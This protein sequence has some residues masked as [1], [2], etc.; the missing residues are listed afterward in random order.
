MPWLSLHVPT[1]VSAAATV[2]AAL[3]LGLVLA[4]RGQHPALHGSLGPWARG[5]LLLAMGWLLLAFRD[6]WPA[7]VSMLLSNTLIGFGLA[8]C[9]DALRRF[10]GCKRRLY[11]PLLLVAGIVL[12][13]AVFGL[14]M[15]D[16][17]LRLTINTALLAGLF[18]LGAREA[19]AAGAELR[20]GTRSHLLVAGVF[21]VAA[22][23]L[24][25]RVAM[26][27]WLGRQDM[28]ASGDINLIQALF[29]GLAALG[30]AVAT[31]GFALMCNDRLSLELRR[32]AEEDA[33]T[34]VSNRRHIERLG[35]H[36]EESGR[37]HSEPFS[38]VLI[39]IDHF[40]RVNDDFG[41]A[42]GDVVLRQLTRIMQEAAEPFGATVGRIGGEEFVLLLHG[43]PLSSALA[44]AES[45]RA[46]AARSA[47]SRLSWTLSAGVAQACPSDAS[48]EALLRR[49][50]R[51]LYAAKR[52]GRNCIRTAE[53][54]APGAAGPAVDGD[55]AAAG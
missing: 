20:S 55:V 21:A 35:R 52:G 26:V 42:Q 46:A 14:A 33:L 29:Y 18:A 32:L 47:G 25:A 19:L 39:D 53:F 5:S 51:A 41:H 12:V 4:V 45:I 22:L 38:L 23:V 54:A 24:V 49:A 9:V 50:D 30:P 7:L 43:Q 16:R 2:N 6:V 31:L 40:K 48:F 28:P 8:Q 15:P 3:A 1:W 37:L 36:L 44:L 27:Q 34:G 13:S 10:R 11:A 17:F